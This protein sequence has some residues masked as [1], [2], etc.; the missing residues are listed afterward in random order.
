MSDHNL[1]H[2]HPVPFTP[3]LSFISYPLPLHRLSHP[4]PC[5]F[6]P[7]GT[8]PPFRFHPAPPP[9]YFT[10]P[11]TLSH[12]THQ[13]THFHTPLHFNGIPALPSPTPS[14]S[15]H[16]PSPLH[17][18][19]IIPHPSP[20]TRSCPSQSSLRL[21]LP[22]SLPVISCSSPVLFCPV[23]SLSWSC[24]IPFVSPFYT[25]SY[26][27][28]LSFCP[29]P[30]SYP[31]P[32]PPHFT[33]LP[34]TTPRSCPFTP[35]CS[36]YILP[37]PS[38]TLPSPSL[39]CHPLYIYIYIYICMYVGMYVCMYVY[40]YIYIYIYS[41]NSKVSCAPE[42]RIW[43]NQSK[44]HWQESF[45]TPKSAMCVCCCGICETLMIKS[46]PCIYVCMEVAHQWF[47][48]GRIHTLRPKQNGRHF[49]DDIFKWIFL[50]QNVWISITISLK[51]VRKSPINNIP[52]LVQIM[53]WRWSGHKP[54]SEPMMVSLQS[55][56]TLICALGLNELFKKKISLYDLHTTLRGYL[57][58][59]QHRWTWEKTN[60]IAL[61]VFRDFN[62]RPFLTFLVR[63]VSRENLNRE[64][65][66]IL[67][68][69]MTIWKWPRLSSRV[70]LV[71]RHEDSI[72][73][74]IALGK[75]YDC[76]R[77]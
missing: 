69:I 67:G 10:L 70:P 30:L 34:N 38:P 33:A 64:N 40:I 3:S 21:W 9:F 36:P 6:T 19:T 51:F 26:A 68:I 42:K 60:S 1:F 48:A 44:Q 7:P 14:N 32:H 4:S 71:R 41:K 29:L 74:C 17:L 16:P 47:R 31:T 39:S 23:F 22:C 50:E 61:H 11:C 12:S 46:S 18:A 55:L 8:I 27:I 28:L 65:Y 43:Y 15:P 25:S 62:L 37:D 77:T 49:P 56:L 53:A 75:W 58:I 59:Y 2:T 24:F 35:P 45:V 5:F 63:N 76:L 13:P 52:A 54:L 20:I 57:C 73:H 66:K 72:V